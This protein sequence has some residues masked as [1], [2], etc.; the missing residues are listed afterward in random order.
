[1]SNEGGAV[2]QIEF[3]DAPRDELVPGEI[4]PERLPG[5]YIL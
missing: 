5:R 1:M 3:D 2:A 4:V